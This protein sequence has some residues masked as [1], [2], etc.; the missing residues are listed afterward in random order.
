MTNEEEYIQTTKETLKKL[1]LKTQDFYIHSVSSRR[2]G[3]G[4]GSEVYNW[5]DID[6]NGESYS[7]GDPWSGKFNTYAKYSFIRTVLFKIL[8]E[9]LSLHDVNK[10]EDKEI[11]ELKKDLNIKTKEKKKK[12]KKKKSNTP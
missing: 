8:P 5:Y 4:Q 10:M 11:E 12:V 6:F 1:G 9:E 2:Y 3:S 7:G